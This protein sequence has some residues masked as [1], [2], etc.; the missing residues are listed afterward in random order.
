MTPAQ[1][2]RI[3]CCWIQRYEA[4]RRIASQLRIA[5]NHKLAKRGI[6]GPPPVTEVEVIKHT[7][8]E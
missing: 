1:S 4:Q 5:I 6:A 3:S 8:N 7:C 2:H